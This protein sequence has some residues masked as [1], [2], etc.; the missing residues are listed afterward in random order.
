MATPLCAMHR[1]QCSIVNQLALGLIVSPQRGQ[2]KRVVRSPVNAG[3]RW[4]RRK[5]GE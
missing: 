1:G 4:G 2:F 5:S 3:A